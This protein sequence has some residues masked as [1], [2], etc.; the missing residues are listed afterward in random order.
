V[1][2]LRVAGG[3]ELR[4]GRRAQPFTA[5]E[6]PDADKPAILRA[7]LTRWKM[8]IGVFFQGVGPDAPEARLAEIAPGYPVFR[9]R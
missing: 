9:I 4:L 1:R 7:Y 5:V 3:G 8:E 6:V 2:N